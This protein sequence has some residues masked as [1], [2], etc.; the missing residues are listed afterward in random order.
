M[1]KLI[2]IGGILIFLGMLGFLIGEAVPILPVVSGVVFAAGLIL[3]VAGTRKA[4]K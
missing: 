3:I 4:A 1:K 2:P